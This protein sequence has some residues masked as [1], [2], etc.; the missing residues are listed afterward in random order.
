M[1][2]FFSWGFKSGQ[3]DGPGIPDS[4]CP[5]E[6]HPRWAL[7][8]YIDGS[9][10]SNFCWE[11]SNGLTVRGN[12][13]GG[14]YAN[15]SIKGETFI[16]G[17]IGGRVAFIPTDSTHYALIIAGRM[18][19]ARNMIGARAVVGKYEVVQRV[20]GTWTTLFSGGAATVGDYVMLM[21][22]A[23]H[24]K[25]IVNEVEVKSGTH[26]LAEIPG[27]W[28]CSTHQ[29]KSGDNVLVRELAWSEIDEV[30]TLN[31]ENV[32]HNGSILYHGD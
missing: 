21:L 23:N 27:Y 16:N 29:V 26:G 7:R 2:G 18:I 11:S 28:G 12:N 8:H 20:N 24:Y 22:S 4:G 5:L 30:V 15:I 31:G 6:A 9:G 1:G 3:P 32:T 13:A 17:T 19:N 10:N 25:L 14:A